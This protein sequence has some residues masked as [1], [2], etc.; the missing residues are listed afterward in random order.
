M[1]TL[2]ATRRELFCLVIGLSTAWLF[3]GCASPEELAAQE[4]GRFQLRLQAVQEGQIYRLSRCTLSIQGRVALM[5]RPDERPQAPVSTPLPV[6]AYTMH[7]QDGWQLV[8]RGTSGAWDVVP[9]AE[10]VSE[11]P[12]SFFIHAQKTTQVGFS[13]RVDD[14]VVSFPVGDVHVQVQIQPGRPCDDPADADK[15]GVPNCH[16]RCPQDPLKWAPM[17]CGC[18]KL[19]VDADLNGVVDCVEKALG[20]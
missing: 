4:Q 13:F 18:G 19:E 1:R 15:D 6:G 5:L 2:G 10:L 17:Y 7:L 9:D 16:D 12:Q 14:A 3:A 20:R 8:K 11:N